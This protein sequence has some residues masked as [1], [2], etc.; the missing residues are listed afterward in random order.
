VRR[1]RAIVIHP[2]DDVAVVLEPAQPGDVIQVEGQVVVVRDAIPRFHKVA[3]RDLEA[4]S[5]VRKVGEVIGVATQ[6]IR[7]GEHVH[8][9]NLRSLRAGAGAF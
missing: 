7:P 9:H 5:V 4:G 3:L 6:S 2:L 1:V 8:I